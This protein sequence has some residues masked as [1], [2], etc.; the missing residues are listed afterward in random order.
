MA[1]GSSTIATDATYVAR[2]GNSADLNVHRRQKSPPALASFGPSAR[3]G[4]DSLSSRNGGRKLGVP[5]I[6]Y[7]RLGKIAAAAA[8]AVAAVY[9]AGE[10]VFTASSLEGT[11]TSPL[12]TIRSPIDGVVSVNG[13]KPGSPVGQQDPVFTVE[14][15]LVDNRLRIELEAKLASSRREILVIDAK[16]ADLEALR[17]DIQQRSATHKAATVA[18]LEYIIAETSAQLSAAKAQ[19]E[20]S[21]TESHRMITLAASGVAAQAKLEDTTLGEQKARFE[22]ERLSAAMKRLNVE[23]SAAKS[24]VLLGEGYSDSP[25]SQQRI[26]ELSM[27]LIELSAERA[28]LE[29]TQRE[30]AA[31]LGAEQRHEDDLRRYAI[32][33]PIDGVVWNLR[34][35]S[36]AVVN[37]DMPLADVVDCNSAF[38]EAVVPDSHYDDL[39]VGERVDVKLRGNDQRLTGTIRSVR[40]QSA[41]IDRNSLAASLNPRHNDS[42][43]VSVEIDRRALQQLSNGVCE[44]GRSAKVVFPDKGTTF[45]SL[46]SRAFAA[47]N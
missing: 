7:S 43:T 25:Y 42:L 32:N 3:P 10:Q 9:F 28:S 16:R 27:H 34:V 24:G 30:L 8:F 19:A 2:Y 23:L 41:V 35:A 5:T 44:I 15:R 13:L 45:G 31:R 47:G 33:S 22:A 18:R 20:R 6:N 46:V 12:I 37:R 11:V 29:N 26:D 39:H 40:G 21:H 17:D 1:D 38:V 36:G 14:D 4:L